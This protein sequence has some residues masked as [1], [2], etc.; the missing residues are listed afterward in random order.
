MRVIR[1]LFVALAL[2]ACLVLPAWAQLTGSAGEPRIDPALERATTSLTG[3]QIKSLEDYVRYW[4]RVM[5]DGTA[6]DAVRARDALTRPF[7][8]G[9]TAIFLSTYSPVLSR[10]LVTAA[11]T[12]DPAAG[13]NAMI[14]ASRLMDPGAIDVI[15]AGL[16]NSQNVSVRYWA[17]RAV[18]TLPVNL[19]K[20][21]P[22]LRLTDADQ[23]KLL[24]ALVHAAQNE[25]S[26]HVLRQILPSIVTLTI[27]EAR[28]ALLEL[29]DQR[30]TAHVSKTNLS[31][32][33]E[34]AALNRL[35]R[36]VVQETFT[37]R[38][39]NGKINEPLLK[40]IA[41]ISYLYL[42]LTSGRMQQPI[43]AERQGE[44]TGMMDLAD[45]FLRFCAEQLLGSSKNFPAKPQDFAGN[46]GRYAAV[47]AQWPV[48]LTAP[49]LGF[50]AD[51][52]LLPKPQS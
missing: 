5:Q 45:S 31:V 37:A 46:W 24:A 29:L 16:K 27:P 32:A 6:E 18:D 50:P 10:N 40:A 35:Y 51:A 38:A 52:L 4:I 43:G 49:P 39:N 34:L 21:D 17:A 9:G 48:I 8:R 47:V 20:R 13:L 12:S 33:P 7:D 19:A 3:E 14:V 41:R 1:G 15:E 2:S 28:K 22:N 30:L 25:S 44:L 42:A 36:Q 26:D 11:K 23:K